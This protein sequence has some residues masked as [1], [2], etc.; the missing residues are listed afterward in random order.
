[1]A[2]K[3]ENL[4]VLSL[5]IGAL[6]VLFILLRLLSGMSSTNDNY[7][8]GKKTVN[9]QT[10]SSGAS[11]TQITGYAMSDGS[12][13]SRI[14]PD[15]VQPGSSFDVTIRS[16][17]GADGHSS[18][19]IEEY[20]PSGFTVIND[21][22]GGTPTTNTLKWVEFSSSP[23]PDKNF[24]YTLQAPMV[25]GDY[26]FS[27][28]YQIEGMSSSSPTEGLTT[29]TVSNCGTDQ[30]YIKRHL[31]VSTNPDE[32]VNVT[33]EVYLASSGASTYAIEEYV[34]SGFTV[35]NDGGGGTP[36]PN[37]L[38]W[39]EF[40]SSPLPNKNFNYAIMAPQQSGQYT[41]FG[42]YQI[43]GMSNSTGI[44]GNDIMTV[45][46]CTIGDSE[47]RFCGSN[48]GQCVSGTETRVCID[49]GTGVGIW[50]E[51]GNCV[52][53][54][55]PS[56]E[57]CDGYDN[58][59][60]GTI[61][62]DLGTTTCGQGVC[63]H[64]IN[65]CEDGVPQTCDPMQ[66]SSPEVCDGN[67]DED[68]DGT[69][70]EGCDCISGQTRQCGTTDVGLCEN[71]T[72][73]CV[74]GVWSN[75]CVGAVEPSED[76][77]DG[78]DNDCDGQTDE[79]LGTTTCGLGECLHTVNNCIAGVP[80]TCDPYQGATTEICDGLDNN[81]DGT[82]DEGC[83]CIDGSTRTCGSNE[84]LCKFGT[85]FCESG[86]WSGECIGGITP[87]DEVCDGDDNDCDGTTDEDME[88]TTCGL[89]ICLHT[90]N[91]CVGGVPQTCDP[92]QGSS[93]E[94]CD[95]NLDED[96]D[97]SVDEGCGCLD[98]ETRQCGTNVGLCEFGTET[99]E[100]GAW[101]GNCVGEVTPTTEVCDGYDNDCN[102]ITDDDLGSTTCGL[103]VC[104]HTVNNCKDRVPQTCDPMQ[105]ATPEVCDGLLDEDCDG[106][107][108]EIC[109]C[110]P[111][112]TQNCGTNVGECSYGLQTC[113]DYG[114]WGVCVGGIEPIPEVCDG[115]DNDCDA[116]IDE[117][118]VCGECTPGE[119]EAQ[120]CGSD[121]G[122]CVSG[123]QS[124]ECTPNRV[125][126]AWGECVGQIG[127][128]PE[129][130][131]Q[132]DNDC[133]SQADEG[134]I[135]EL[136]TAGQVE[137]RSC[138]SAVGE[139]VSGEQKRTC[140]AERQWS[141]WGDCIG[142]VAPVAEICDGKDNDCD[143][144][145]D[146][147]NV[148]GLCTVGEVQTESC[149]TDVGVCELG[150]HTRTCNSRKL[151]G[152]WRKCIGGVQPTREVCDGWDNDC[153]GLVDEKCGSGGSGGLTC[154]EKWDCSDW[155][156]EC[157]DGLNFRECFEINGCGTTKH[158]PSET[159]K[160]TRAEWKEFWDKIISFFTKSSNRRSWWG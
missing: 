50:D 36:S 95:G 26:D 34:P 136:C 9:Q 7:I 159:K 31:P 127:P 38:K 10:A 44:Q 89:G 105:G 37:T 115:L 39:I 69:V 54:V 141:T 131:D 24:I 71:G 64:T 51:W 21:S 139:C 157:V 6:F 23:L 146:E 151:W 42:V 82:T 110:N 59:C 124:R 32:I 19:A 87:T 60:D 1:M 55:S 93:L 49:D 155:S 14:I 84:G 30:P 121:I 33:I 149:G 156:T 61:D 73:T 154:R 2:K 133:D 152:K 137:T 77:C 145:I 91:N 48:V 41:F 158:K 130:C 132:I 74:G 58:D 22:N 78:Y 29:I 153:D 40:S 103:G 100:N 109:E 62:E 57:I 102:G 111:G 11:F 134:G 101:S 148:C 27:G 16:H 47:D 119:V 15:C 138:G 70:D 94:V 135:C 65:N 18:Y 17:L 128:S 83:D 3:K 76:I 150:T 117:D 80:Q 144:K 72:E 92:M 85:E 75:N 142:S 129:I 45:T 79:D 8:Y 114:Q 106:E 63:L 140:D 107:V 25:N 143:T 96:C 53:G 98:G 20:V 104:L 160:C 68:C 147:G 113:N 116:Q 112:D 97:G 125:W 86:A 66:G 46:E 120:S 118:D 43:E 67:L 35:I 5:V 4:D 81:C 28:L 52:G 88:T 56:A 13:V 122:A 126:G 90:E 108:D 12:A 123:T 99:C